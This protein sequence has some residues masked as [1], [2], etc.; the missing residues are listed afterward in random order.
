METETKNTK[1][2]TKQLQPATPPPKSPT[3]NISN[4]TMRSRNRPD[5]INLDSNNTNANDDKFQR[6]VSVTKRSPFWTPQTSTSNDMAFIFENKQTKFVNDIMDRDE[7]WMNKIQDGKMSALPTLETPHAGSHPYTCIPEEASVDSPPNLVQQL[8]VG[9]VGM[10]KP[11]TVQ[12]INDGMDKL[13][14]LQTMH[15]IDPVTT[16][17]NK[18]FHD[19]SPASSISN[20]SPKA[21]TAAK[22]KAPEDMSF[23]DLVDKKLEEKLT[24]QER[25]K[26][27]W[28]SQEILEAI[29]LRDQLF[30]QMKSAEK[31]T[32]EYQQVANVYKKQRNQVVTLTRR[33]KRDWKNSVRMNVETEIHVDMASKVVQS[34]PTTLGLFPR[35]PPARGLQ[36]NYRSMQIQE[37]R[38]PP[39]GFL[40]PAVQQHR[41][42]QRGYHSNPS[43]SPHNS[44][45]A[46]TPRS[47][48]NA[49]NIVRQPIGPS[50][51][52]QPE[53]SN[54]STQ[55]IKFNDIV[56]RK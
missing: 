50:N 39:P 23:T 2:Q 36:Q 34:S 10:G 14:L 32:P 20:S 44:S 40:H 48:A 17:V 28:M 49:A 5:P 33:A 31:G 6:Q 19:S 25:G 21:Q 1:T 37:T 55:R 53:F 12:E 22:Q 15:S 16:T 3:Q 4:T 30:L 41:G 51:A 45:G 13:K 38:T 27:E 26:K 18:I 52:S 43:R 8:P 9:P 11:P 42:I 29:E 7:D 47:Y 35:G 56:R 46:N 24:E 54:Q